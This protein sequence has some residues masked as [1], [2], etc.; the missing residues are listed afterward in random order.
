MQNKKYKTILADPPWYQRGGGKVKRGADKHYPILKEAQIKEIMSQ[1]LNGNVEDDAHLY[2]WVANNHLPEALR[3]IEHLGFR[4]ITNLVWAK[5]K[6]GLGR[7]F[8]G[9][10]EICLFA[11][12]GRGFGV[13]TDIN[14][15]SSLLG[16]GLIAPSRHSQKPYEMYELIESR[17]QGPY[18]ELFARATRPGW[19]SWGAEVNEE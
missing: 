8:R 18:L 14:N 12:R 13:R 6:F 2:L 11:T 19:D 5:S 7:Y 17:S 15:V 10:H 1:Q 3:I 16:K 9:Q 4:Y